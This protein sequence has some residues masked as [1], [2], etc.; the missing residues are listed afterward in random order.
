MLYHVS[1]LPALL[2]PCDGDVPLYEYI[3]CVGAFYFFLPGSKMILSRG[4]GKPAGAL[5]L[6][7]F[8]LCASWGLSL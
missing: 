8:L 3:T 1:T 7:S 6:C 2:R 4:L 5:L